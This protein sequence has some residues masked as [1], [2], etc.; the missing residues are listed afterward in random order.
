MRLLA[1]CYCIWWLCSPLQVVRA[2]TTYFPVPAAQPGT[3]ASGGRGP[4]GAVDF[5]RAAFLY[6]AA[7]VALGNIPNGTVLTS[8][9]FHIFTPAA[10]AA[11]G[12]LRVWM[13]ATPATSFTRSA[14]WADLLAAA[15]ALTKVYDGPLTIPA[16][17][18]FYDVTF[19]QPGGLAPY[20][21]GTGYFIVYEWIAATKSAVS[22][23]YTVSVRP[24]TFYMGLGTTP[25]AVLTPTGGSRP[26]MRLGAG[27][28][29]VYPDPAVLA[30]PNLGR[31]PLL[32]G[33]ATPVVV[34]AVV[35]NHGTQVVRNIPVSLSVTGPTPFQATLTLDSL[36]AHDTTTV[37]F[38]GF[39]PLQ[40]G[41]YG[42]RVSL[43]TV[44]DSI[45]TNNEQADS[46][47]VT[48][49]QISYGRG[50]RFGTRP[51]SAIGFGAGSGT[52]LHRYEAHTPVAVAAARVWLAPQTRNLGQ[53][54]F[55]VVLD[56]TGRLLGRSADHVIAP[57][58]L[59]EFTALSLAV[60]VRVRGTYFVGVAQ[61]AD[62][63][64]GAYYPVG[65]QVEPPPFVPTMAYY[66]AAGDSALLGLRLPREL[67]QLGRPLLGADLTSVTGLDEP[68]AEPADALVVWPNPANEMVNVQVRKAAGTLML[69]Q[70]T[71]QLVQT[72]HLSGQQPLLF[73]VAGLAPGAYYLRF[74]ATDGIYR[75][76]ETKLLIV[77]P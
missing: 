21:T 50:T 70:L 68:V 63:T 69:Y 43:P 49:A 55:G 22:A 33:T 72:H 75:P 45:T 16:Q 54:I 25:P 42:I 53:T 23:T 27:G 41:G 62:P 67:R 20:Q 38:P 35:A 24:A 3:I 60:P 58:D 61:L 47:L 10:S 32:N 17:A 66:E 15:P 13:G 46:L 1:F 73:N 59:G 30:L 71:G 11:A 44:G 4:N 19:N 12:T 2:Q 48:P 57:V 36:R 77:A 74:V 29:V 56:S 28:G 76:V 14:V 64:G 9:G 37:S 8:I 34:Q 5:H 52:L 26:W 39:T 65:A 31:L 7:D 40:P 51:T 6:T 18:G